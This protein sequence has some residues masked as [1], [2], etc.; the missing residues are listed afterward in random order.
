MV[1][2]RAFSY[3]AEN[4]LRRATFDSPEEAATLSK[5]PGRPSPDGSAWVDRREKDRAG[6]ENL[7]SRGRAAQAVGWETRAR[8]GLRERPHRPAAAWWLSPARALEPQPDGSLLLHRLG[9]KWF[10]SA[11]VKIHL[12]NLR[13]KGCGFHPAA[14]GSAFALAHGSELAL[15]RSEDGKSPAHF[16][17]EVPRR[18]DEPAVVACWVAPQG[19]EFLVILQSGHWQHWKINV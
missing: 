11:T 1:Q 10:G 5:I 19:R 8:G 16:A 7:A 2:N 18:P 4:E 3:D 15:Y 14:D 12:S 9:K 17:L 13:L 6:Q